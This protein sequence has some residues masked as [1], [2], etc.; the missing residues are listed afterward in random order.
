MRQ[1]KSLF[2]KWN[3]DLIFKSLNNW[4]EGSTVGTILDL[5]FKAV[6]I[7]CGLFPNIFFVRSEYYTVPAMNELNQMTDSNGDVFVDD[8]VVG[9]RGYGRVKFYGRTNVAGLNLDE[10]GKGFEKRF[11]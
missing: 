4:S 5:L 9:R 3:F 2:N 7:H 10:I 1:T 11:L 6:V 8:F